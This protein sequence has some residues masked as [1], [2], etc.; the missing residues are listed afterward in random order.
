MN[1]IRYPQE[2]LE[3][4]DIFRECFTEPQF[5]N[6]CR[7]LFGLAVNESKKNIETINSS[8]LEIINQATLNN[9]VTDS[10]WD[11]QKLKSTRINLINQMICEYSFPEEEIVF[12][13]D[14]VVIP[15]TGKDMDGAGY[16]FSTTAGKSIWGHNFV[17]SFISCPPIYSCVDIWQYFKKDFC[18]KNDIKFKKKTDAAAEQILEY[19]VPKDRKVTVT[20]DSFYLCKKIIRPIKTRNWQ[21]ISRLKINRVIYYH[22]KKMTVSDILKQSVKEL[23]YRFSRCR[24]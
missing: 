19:N 16:F 1:T 14:D 20:M 12:I 8:Y 7:Y 24:R 18:E 2:F 21:W 3:A 4:V 10:P 17:S 6:F 5:S 15:K 13:L 9:F 22:D 23:D 11:Y